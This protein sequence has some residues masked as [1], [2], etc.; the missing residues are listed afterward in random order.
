MGGLNPLSG[1]AAIVYNGFV[2]FISLAGPLPAL[3]VSDSSFI[4]NEA[5][6]P[7]GAII[8]YQIPEPAFDFEGRVRFKRNVSQQNATLN[9]AFE[10]KLI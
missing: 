4:K 5:T 6:G 7:G 3:D 1:G 9:N 2:R 8:A 10:I